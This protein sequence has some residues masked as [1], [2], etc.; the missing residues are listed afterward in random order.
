MDYYLPLKDNPK[1]RGMVPNP[2]NLDTLH[3]SENPVDD[4]VIIF[5]GINRQTYNQKGISYF[6]K[7][8]ELI[9]AKYHDKVEIIIAESLPY[10][11]YIKLYDRA[12]ILLDQVYA[13]DQ[14]Y[15]ALEAMAKGKVVFTGAEKEFMEYYGLTKSVAINALPDAD[16]LTKELSFLIENPAEITAMGKRARGFIEK[17]HDYRKGAERYLEVWEK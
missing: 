2:V 10:N 1:L 4:K 8:L 11:E 9:K 12:H 17:E 16:Y 14:G 3:Y 13:Y 15:N 5:M 6:E 7:A